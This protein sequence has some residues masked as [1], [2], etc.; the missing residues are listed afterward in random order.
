[1]AG[2]E[3]YVKLLESQLTEMR[4]DNEKTMSLFEKIMERQPLLLCRLLLFLKLKDLGLSVLLV[5]V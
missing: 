3:A 4:K 1:M 2:F 5:E